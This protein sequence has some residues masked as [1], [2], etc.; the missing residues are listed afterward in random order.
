MRDD[1]AIS[2]VERRVK[3]ALRPREEE[4][5]RVIAAALGPGRQRRR[6]HVALVGAALLALALA[7]AILWRGTRPP[8]SPLMISGSGGVVVVTSDDGR[9]WL[10]QAQ[11][12]PP[13][14]GEYVIAFPQ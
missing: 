13:V 9:R 7:T 8:P 6:S 4:V 1:D 3:L 2:D 14:Q 11:Q 10:I 12:A 5:E